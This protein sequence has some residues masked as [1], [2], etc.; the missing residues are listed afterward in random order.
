MYPLLSVAM[1]FSINSFPLSTGTFYFFH[2]CCQQAFWLTSAG[3]GTMAVTSA[4]KWK[5]RCAAV[6]ACSLFFER[7]PDHLGHSHGN[8]V[9]YVTL[10][11]THSDS[12][13]S[14]LC[15]APSRLPLRPETWGEQR[16]KTSAPAVE[17]VPLVWSVLLHALIISFSEV[18]LVHAC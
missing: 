8:T 18:R 10:A 14:C 9:H 1:P 16:E 3:F 6:E 5:K 17:L 7:P 4:R 13:P 11:N 12:L 15:L 2:A